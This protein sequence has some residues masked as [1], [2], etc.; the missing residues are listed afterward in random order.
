M[1]HVVGRVLA[2]LGLLL[3]LVAAGLLAKNVID[4]NQLHAVAGANRSVAYPNPVNNVALN[5]ALAVLAGVLMGLGLAYGSRR[6][7]RTMVEPDMNGA[8]RP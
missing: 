3:L 2:I 7:R 8:P 1:S 5:C 6:V 4:I